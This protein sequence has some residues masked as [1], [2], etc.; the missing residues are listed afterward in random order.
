[1][2]RGQPNEGTTHWFGSSAALRPAPQGCIPVQC[3]TCSDLYIVVT[4]Q[5]HFPFRFAAACCVLCITGC[6]PF[7]WGWGHVAG[8][9]P[10]LCGSPRPP[11]PPSAAAGEKGSVGGWA[12]CMAACRAAPGA[13]VRVRGV[14]GGSAWAIAALAAARRR[15]LLASS[16]AR[17]GSG[18][19][20]RWRSGCGGGSDPAEAEPS[21]TR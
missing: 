17:G 14:L 13:C 20:S 6:R 11:R 18:G 16:V 3:Y 10:A 15:R 4:L 8:R 7:G 19:A 9:P 5:S 2:S 1:M 12:P 21:W